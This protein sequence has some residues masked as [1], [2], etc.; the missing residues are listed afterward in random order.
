MY[1][2]AWESVEEHKKIKMTPF[3][4]EVFTESKKVWKNVELFGH[5]LLQPVIK[6]NEIMQ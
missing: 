4:Q 1:I 2:V 5:V 6:F 3:F